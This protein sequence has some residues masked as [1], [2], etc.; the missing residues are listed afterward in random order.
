L[1]ASGYSPFVLLPTMHIA[2]PESRVSFAVAVGDITPPNGIYHRMWGAA[3]HDRATGVHRPLRATVM[4]FRS[5]DGE[6]SPQDQQIVIALDHCLLGAPEM[7]QLLSHVSQATGAPRES[8]LVTFSHTHAAGLMSLDRADLPGGDLIPG[9]LG[10][11]AQR[12]AELTAQALG[13]LADATIVYGEGR[14]SLAAHRDYWDEAGGRFVCGYNPHAPA[15]DAVLVARVTREADGV[16]LAVVVNYACHP[17]TLA[18]DNTLVSPDFPGAMRETVEAAAGA[19]CVF[20]QG[21]SGDLGPKEGFV[22]DTAVADRNGR[23]LGYA[24]LAV[25]ESLPP[26]GTQFEY[27]GAVESGATIGVWKHVPRSDAAR[28]FAAPWRMRRWSVELPYRDDLPSPDVVERERDQWQAKEDEAAAR[29]DPAAARDARAMVERRTRL[30]RRLA[31]LPEGGAYPFPIT[32]WRSGDAWWLAVSGEP[33]NQL[34]T[35]LRRRWPEA[36]IMVMTLAGGWG[37]SYL[38]PRELY[39]KGIY[40]ESVSALAPGCLETLIEAIDEGMKTLA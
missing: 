27:A 34:Q 15:D 17:T 23:Q 32:L 26:P 38:P 24:A 25:L 30:L 11:I 12:T 40:Q 33:Y 37:P 22:G 1:F 9:Y 18:W 13:N 39:G 4:V 20:L 8:F 7:N 5:K 10:Q 28:S 29:G 16:M 36:P 6:R 35:E 21:A 3:V 2:A 31:T 14:C 19:P